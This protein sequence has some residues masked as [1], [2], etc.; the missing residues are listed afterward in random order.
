[1]SFL[2]LTSESLLTQPS[3]GE[4]LMLL[5]QARLYTYILESPFPISSVSATPVDCTT[6]D[7]RLSPRDT[8][9]LL[10]V[11]CWPQSCC[12]LPTPVFNVSGMNRGDGKSHELLLM[13]DFCAAALALLLSFGAGYGVMREGVWS[14]ALGS[15]TS[16]PEAERSNREE[17]LQ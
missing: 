17:V 11:A 14:F 7:S 9:H 12:W 3:E 10:T 2:V 6:K 15:V 5:L 13:L 8:A 4:Y 1:M 16:Q